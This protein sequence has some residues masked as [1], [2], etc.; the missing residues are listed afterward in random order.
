MFS[1]AKVHFTD[2]SCFVDSKDMFCGGSGPTNKVFSI[3][4]SKIN[5]RVIL[6]WRYT[7]VS[8]GKQ[9]S[10]LFNLPG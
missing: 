3:T 1:V 5:T 7:V 8:T 4:H 2:I 10:I 6:H 9:L